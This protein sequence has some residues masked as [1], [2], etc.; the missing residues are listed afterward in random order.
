MKTDAEIK[1]DVENELR[2]SPYLDS[3]DIAVAVK[4]GTVELAGFATSYGDSVAAEE[5]AK[6]VSGVVGLAND[7]EVRLPTIDRRPDPDIARDAVAAIQYQLPVSSKDIKPT[8]KDGWVTLEGTV[9]WYY[10]KETAE[11]AVRRLKGVKG[12]SNTIHLVPHAAPV[13]VKQKI[14]E[15]FKRHAAI[16]ASHITVDASGGD[17]TLRGYVRS[18]DERS[19]AEQAAW[20]A[21]GVSNVDDRL[22]INV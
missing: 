11:T 12:V 22:T 14:E 3:T 9:E 19:Q 8:V 1:R 20:A 5:A 6:R 10:E 18:W 21:P 17:V 4:N 16:D 2:W 15:A 13:E 7:I